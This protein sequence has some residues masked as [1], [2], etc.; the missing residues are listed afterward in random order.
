MT[1]I[2]FPTYMYVRMYSY[3]IYTP[4]GKVLFVTWLEFRLVN[5]IKWVVTYHLFQTS[6]HH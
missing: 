3:L 2:Y 5:W 6:F 1:R 4:W